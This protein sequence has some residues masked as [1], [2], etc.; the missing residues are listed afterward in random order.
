MSRALLFISVIAAGCGGNDNGPDAAPAS[1][2]DATAVVD[3][4]RAADAGPPDAVA[5][6]AG[7]TVAGRIT[8]SGAQVG[9]IVIGLYQSLPPTGPPQAFSSINDPTFPAD[10]ELTDVDAGTYQLMVVFDVGGNNPMMPGDE[11]IQVPS[12]PITITDEV[13]VWLDVAIEDQ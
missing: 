1:T 9:N 2:V 3:S 4:A 11:D 8:Y 10:F 12:E 6:P 5:A 7:N 13:G